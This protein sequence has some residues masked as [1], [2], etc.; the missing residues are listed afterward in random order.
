VKV[1]DAEGE[2]EKEDSSLGRAT[3]SDIVNSP[4]PKSDSLDQILQSTD[5]E[6]PNVPG[7]DS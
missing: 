1:R 5:A 6:S 3:E 4:E 7:G 2:E